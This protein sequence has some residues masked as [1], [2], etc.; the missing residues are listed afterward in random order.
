MIWRA[1]IIGLQVLLAGVVMAGGGL[2]LVAAVPAAQAVVVDRVAAVVNDSVITW[3]EVYELGGEHIETEVRAAG[4]SEAVRRR[5]ELD[6]LDVLVDRQLV[7]QEMKRLDIDVNEADI[8]RALGDICKQ[9]GLEREQ[10]R[11]EIENAGLE[12]EAYLTELKSN[13]REMKFSGQVLGPRIV[14]RDDDLEDLYRRQRESLAGPPTVRLQAVFIPYAPEDGED[15]VAHAL[16]SAQAAREEVMAGRLF[17]EVVARWSVEP[18]SSTGGD[19]GSFQKGDLVGTLDRAAFALEE[20]GVS[21][22]I[23]TPQGVFILRAAKRIAAQ[24]PALDEIRDEL[25][26]QL[27]MEKTEEA[28]AQWL[29]QAR[30]RASVKVLLEPAD[31]E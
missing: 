14:T 8:E 13:L 10:L 31:E 26:Q 30:R 20:G 7:E 15:A 2:A 27:M 23:V 21:E 28:R 6:V 17:E 3:S 9:N 25:E 22:P 18:Y 4:G 29:N 16:A 11:R 19:M 5:L 24:P 12:W 1:R